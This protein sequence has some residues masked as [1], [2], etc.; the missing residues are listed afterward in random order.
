MF[1]KA[2]ECLISR[3]TTDWS[4][5]GCCFAI[6]TVI[7]SLC[8]IGDLEGNQTHIRRRLTNHYTTL[9]GSALGINKTPGTYWWGYP[10][11]KKQEQRIL[12]LL[13]AAEYYED[14]G[15]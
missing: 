15:L 13:F 1:R 12:G 2:A 4:L 14:L 3:D 5:V 9:L 8:A 10:D 11:L 6:R 7:D